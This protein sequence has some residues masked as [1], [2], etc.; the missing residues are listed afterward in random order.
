MCSPEEAKLLASQMLGN[1]L[2][3]KQ[4]GE[5]GRICNAVMVTQRMFP[6][7]E[8]YLA[9]MMERAFG[10]SFLKKRLIDIAYREKNLI[11]YFLSQGPVIIASSQ[12]GV[13][14]EEVAATNPSAIMYEP[15]DINK[16]I[17]KEQAERIVNKL[18]LDNMKDYISNMII[19]LYQ[20]FLKKDAV[21]LEVNPLAEDINGNCKSEIFCFL[22][23]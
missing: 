12:G 21:L 14:I 23:S 22:S 2:I 9:V 3:T 15:I 10:V 11:R 19:N 6:R 17:T 16:G 18:G 5:A 8:Y 7:K 13:N 4:T 20:M 1:L